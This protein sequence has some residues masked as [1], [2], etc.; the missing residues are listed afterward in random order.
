MWKEL[1]QLFKKDNLFEQA[2]QE[3]AGMLDTD[4]AMYNALRRGAAPLGY[5]RGEIRHL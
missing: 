1:I 3:A 4:A 2:Y 5:R